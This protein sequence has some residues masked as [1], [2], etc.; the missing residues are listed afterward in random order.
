MRGRRPELKAVDGGLAASAPAPS[1]IPKAVMAEW[2]RVTS[3]LAARALLTP[4]ALGAVAS[5]CLASFTIMQCIEA[6]ERDGAFVR[7]A[8][9]E[10]KSHPAMAVMAKSHDLIAR[11]AGELGLTPASR[12]RKGLQGKGGT[13]DDGAP[14]G[15]DL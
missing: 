2:N 12:S 4:A 10:P 9:G 3:D 8:E 15:M 13:P 5:Y 1:H 7:T 14:P 6:I 11:L